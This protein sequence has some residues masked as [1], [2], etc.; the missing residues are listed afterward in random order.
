MTKKKVKK[1]GFRVI[2]FLFT[3]CLIAGGYLLNE[4]P[5]LPSSPSV[6][7]RSDNGLAPSEELASSVLTE[8]VRR[9]LGDDIVYNGA[10]AFIVNG[11]HTNLNASVASAPYA[12]NKTKYAQGQLVPTVANALLSKATRQYQSREKTGNGST[13]WRPAGWYQLTDLEGTYNHAIDRGHLLA[14]SLIGNVKGYDASTSNPKNIA[15]QTAWANQSNRSDATGQH[16]F[17]TKIRKALDQNKRVRYRVTLIY[18][19][20]DDLVSVGSHLEAKSTD[21]SLE[22]NVFVPNVQS[23]II[24]DY[25]S[26]QTYLNP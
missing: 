6:S 22:F 25:Y 4:P 15:V 8:E 2:P 19:S 14:Y 3:L 20:P 24:I 18:Q 23:G 9:Q 17:E 16:Y 1:Q 26:G 12:D 7:V 21:G 5:L 13:S 10:G 11:N